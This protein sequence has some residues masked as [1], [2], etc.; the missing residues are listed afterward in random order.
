M[1]ASSKFRSNLKSEQYAV[2][3]SMKEEGAKWK[4]ILSA[5]GLSHS[6]AELAWMEHEAFEISDPPFEVE[7]LTPEFVA[8]ARND[9]RIGWGPIMV[10]TQSSEGKVRKAWE[11]AS[12]THSECQRIGRGGRFK[13]DDAELYVGELKP[14]GTPVPA[15]APL[16][17]SVARESA[18][19]TRLLALD[20]LQ[21]KAIY[22]KY[23]GEP[24]K[25]T[26]KAKMV[27][28]LKKVNAE[29]ALDLNVAPAAP[30]KA[31]A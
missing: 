18:I 30:A 15:E 2:L 27:L 9:L 3:V 1:S 17:R 6:K 20:A 11:A 5:T 12:A 10:W 4:A 26:T 31:S 7:P 24:K 22:K 25:G 14:T 16:A 29:R 13:F 21:V 23:I 19:V 8:F 28:E